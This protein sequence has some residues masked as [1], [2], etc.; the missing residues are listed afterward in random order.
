MSDIE[1]LLRAAMIDRTNTLT[2]SPG[3]AR[4]AIRSAR[5]V[6]SVQ[7]AATTTAAIAAFGAVAAAGFEAQQ[8]GRPASRPAGF[9]PLGPAPA[10]SAVASPVATSS[11][12]QVAS[13]VA[14]APVVQARVVPVPA[15]HAASPLSSSTIETSTPVPT[16]VPSVNG[17]IIGAPDA[18]LVDVTLPDPA[19]GFVLR[20]APDTMDEEGFS[21]GVTY[22]GAVFLLG[23]TPGATSTP[24]PGSIEVDPTGPEATIIVVD[25]HPWDLTS[26]TSI[27]NE[28]V[29]SSLTV[30]GHPAYVTT[31]SDQTDLYLQTGRFQVLVAGSRGTPVDK[32]VALENALT[33]LQ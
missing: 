20:R 30:Q 33:G 2:A 23:V 3:L 17:K 12:S 8:S 15:S 31:S 16:P 27:E 1:A 28:P 5:R 11:A 13:P 7:Y 4:R 6:R 22:P 21:E 9:G 25:G 29:T 19:P 18:A 32:L 24:A 14:S 10:G 26:P